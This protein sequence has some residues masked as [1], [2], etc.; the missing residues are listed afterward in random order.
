MDLAS[1]APKCRRVASVLICHS[2][3]SYLTNEIRNEIVRPGWGGGWGQ[4]ME[5]TLSHTQPPLGS[6]A[7]VARGQIIHVCSGSR[8]GAGQEPHPRGTGAALEGWALSG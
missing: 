2:I 4:G 8:E 5:A 7:L 1:P 3:K 6:G